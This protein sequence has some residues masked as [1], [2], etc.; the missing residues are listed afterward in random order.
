MHVKKGDTVYVR[1]GEDRGKTGK[2]LHVDPKKNTVIVEGINMRTKHQR[3]TQKNPKG[4]LL[5]IEGPINASN[6]SVFNSTVNGPTR[7]GFRTVDAGGGKK[8]RVRYCKKT[9]EEI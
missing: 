6:V 7:V 2:V 9:G 3:P 5:T 1:S 4:G 8:H